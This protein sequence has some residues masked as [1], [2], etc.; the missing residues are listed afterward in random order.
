M[1]PEQRPPTPP[2]APG[3]GGDPLVGRL[4]DGRYRVGDRVA[5]GGMATVYEATDIRLDRV[6]AVKIMHAGLG[7]PITGNDTFAA[8]FV[9]EAR[10]AASLS[11]PNVV[12]V[13]DQG[14]DDGVVFLVMEYVPGRTLRDVVRDQSPMG[15]SR[16]LALLEPVVGAVAAAH[17]AGIVHRDVKPENVLIAEDGRVKVADFGLAKA[18]DAETQHTTTG[19]VLIGTVSYLAPELVIDGKSDAR[20]DVYALGVVLY[21]LLT[22]RKPHEGETPIQIAYKHVHAD[23]PPPS[24]LAPGLP[25]YVDALV[26]RATAR[27]R[28]HRPADA[29]VLLHQVRRVAH[30]LAEGVAV[31]EDL[32]A[33]LLPRRSW[34]DEH[35]DT[36]EQV[37]LAELEGEGF[38]DA[39]LFPALAQASGTTEVRSTDTQVRRAAAP[40]PYGS[41]PAPA[42]HTSRLRLD[43]DPD[44]PGGPGGPGDGK[45]GVPPRERPRRNVRRRRRILAVVLACLLVAGG[46]TAWW[47]FDGR[48]VDAPRV[49]DLTQAEATDRLEAAGFAVELGEPAYSDTIEEGHVVGSDPEGGDDVL[50]GSTITLTISLGI[51]VYAIP[52]VRDLSVDEAQDEL[53]DRKLE[54]AG[55][56]D[57]FDEEIEAGRVIATDP[58]IGEIVRP[59]TPVTLVVSAGRR[60]ITVTDF[61]GRSADE[62]RSALEGGDPELEGDE[63]TVQVNEEFSED[64]PSGT[65]IR[66][67]PGSGTLFLGD[68]VTLTV[69]KGPE[70]VTIPDGLVR[71][72]VGDVRGQLEGLGLVVEEQPIAGDL[73]TLGFVFSV[74]PGS[75][76]QVRRGSTVRI[77]V[78]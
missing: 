4:L 50:P 15:A 62:A 33:D 9:R 2:G 65:V 16:A 30:A 1:L 53:T 19:G 32:V 23:V 51:E 58:A 74:D 24:R 22:G 44:G 78:F 28:S 43:G 63:L 77:S 71:R 57:E 48:Y 31:D 18:V 8:R 60:P 40:A 76:E 56:T 14:N 75:G 42:E 29:S 73:P 26:A 3:H 27:D 61:T 55:S 46:A 45:D 52:E 10:A 69:S 12:A 34:A 35:P 7:D 37:D 49:L 59:G 70:L 13:H 6:V 68:T 36:E 17:R 54:Y 66:Q 72:S 20:A 21:E 38:E 47:F 11:H 67:D 39:E 25:A 5:R 41:D 64:V